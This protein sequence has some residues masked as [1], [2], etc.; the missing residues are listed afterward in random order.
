M[1]AI[2]ER[3]RSNR[4]RTRREWATAAE[5]LTPLRE[6]LKERAGVRITVGA[7][8]RTRRRRDRSGMEH[9]TKRGRK[10]TGS[11][12]SEGARR[13]RSRPGGA[14]P[15]GRLQRQVGNRALHA[16]SKRGRLAPSLEVGRPDGPA[17][18]EAE[19]VA[20]AVMRTP[21]SEP[22][23]RVVGTVRTRSPNATSGSDGPRGGHTRL[24]RLCTDCRERFAAGEPLDCTACEAELASRIE[25][26]RDDPSADGRTAPIAGKTERTIH[27]ATTGGKPLPESTRAFFESRF[28]RD[29]PAVRIHT[30]SRA[31]RAARAVNAEAF[32]L[33]SD[34][35]FRRGT[36]RPDSEAGRHL[37]AHEL[38]HVLQHRGRAAGVSTLRRQR[39]SKTPHGRDYDEGVAHDHQPCGDWEEI[40]DRTECSVFSGDDGAIEGLLEGGS[41]PGPVGCA[42]KLLSPEGVLDAAKGMRM[43]SKPLARDHFEHYLSGGDDYEE[44]V[45]SF[46]IGD[47]G[48]QR[49]L[50]TAALNA[51]RGQFKVHQSTYEDQDYRF[52][53]GAI[54]NFDYEVD[55]AAEVVHVWFADRYE[56][57]PVYKGLYTKKSGDVARATNC[58]HAAAVEM[59]A[60]GAN[61][62]WMYGHAAI[63]FEDLSIRSGPTGLEDD[64]PE[65]TL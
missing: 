59:K 39:P 15:V 56:W 18:R 54:D 65:I 47:A 6:T 5:V 22:P 33:G 21:A 14:D 7:P 58:V 42:C 37:L 64:T 46:V 20:D 52:A 19:R 29:I 62:Y 9:A 43:W 55:R 61:D 35:V 13:S 38:T 50:R 45:E 60:E 11:R 34:V 63:E 30:G 57:H 40:Q 8:E 53:F 25:R 28:G 51:D 32:T 26:R 36:Y 16:L 24:H 3:S 1:A 49:R 23:P 44:D 10:R 2:L 27:T 41:V 31:D 17:E 12:S 4:G 48:V